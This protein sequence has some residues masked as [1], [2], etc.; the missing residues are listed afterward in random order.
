MDQLKLIASRDSRSGSGRRN[1]S[2]H[3]AENQRSHV[4]PSNVG[5]E[6]ARLDCLAAKANV[7]DAAWVRVQ[8]DTQLHHPG[9][10]LSLFGAR[11][12][13]ARRPA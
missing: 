13:A 1:V 8:D 9:F 10:R 7:V 3:R 11:S 2:L 6:Q 12:R 4:A 5:Q